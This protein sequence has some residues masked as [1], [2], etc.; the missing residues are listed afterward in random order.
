MNSRSVKFHSDPSLCFAFLLPLFSCV[1]A[2]STSVSRC[3]SCYAY[4]NYQCSFEK[5]GWVC[6]L[7]SGFNEFTARDLKYAKATTRRTVPELREG[8]VE[9]IHHEGDEEEDEDAEHDDPDSDSGPG[10]DAFP[11]TRPTV[12]FLIDA[13][14]PSEYLATVASAV[15]AALDASHPGSL[16]GIASFGHAL[17]VYD[18]RTGASLR[19]PLSDDADPTT[20]PYAQFDLADTWPLEAL[21]QPVRSC[22]ESV[23]RA[24]DAMAL[25]ATRPPAAAPR[26]NFGAA[27]Q[28]LLQFVGAH[29]L[30]C[31]VAPLEGDTAAPTVAAPATGAASFAP[32]P[33]M[34]MNRGPEAGPPTLTRVVSISGLRLFAFLSAPPAEGRG[35]VR[36]SSGSRPVDDLTQKMAGLGGV[37][38]PG[39]PPIPP[40][41]PPPPASAAPADAIAIELPGALAGGLSSAPGSSFELDRRS[42]AFYE[43]A[44][45]AASA[46]GASIDLFVHP[47][48]GFSGV[49]ALAPLATTTGGSVFVYPDATEGTVAQDVLL[50]LATRRAIGCMLRLRTSTEFRVGRAYGHFVPDE[51][52]EDLHHIGACDPHASFAFDFEFATG[53]GFANR[54]GLGSV[55]SPCVQMAFAYSVMTPVLEPPAGPA[56]NGANA[57]TMSPPPPAAS[58][59]GNDG[60]GEELSFP[61]SIP[62]GNPAGPLKPAA[63]PRRILRWVLQRRLRIM[64]VPMPVASRADMLFKNVEPDT[65]CALLVHKV[66]RAAAAEGIDEARALLRDWLVLL[67]SCCVYNRAEGFVTPQNPQPATTEEVLSLLPEAGVGQGSLAI[68]QLPLAVQPLPRLVFA[69]LRSPLLRPA[70]DT[71][72]LDRRAYLQTLW[73]SLAPEELSRAIYPCLSSFVDQDTPGFPRHTLSRA[74]LGASGCS[75]FLLDAYDALMVY[76]GPACPREV[77]FPPPPNSLLRKTVQVLR[78]SRRNTP[79]VH[80]MRAGVDDTMTF[81]ACLVEEPRV[82]ESSFATDEGYLDFAD[83]ILL[84]TRQ[85]IKENYKEGGQ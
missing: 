3:R 30:Q 77:P 10:A 65:C 36:L 56:P 84:E 47:A 72:A 58:G 31:S 28:A 81:D 49:E 69:L 16:V 21:L 18:M 75:L 41:P 40:P 7:C 39:F 23:L 11:E 20:S 42:R 62:L 51:E 25:A 55:G 85:Y 35:A 4:I 48:S 78:T 43:E 76:Y 33:V 12:L 70:R 9:L 6:S 37:G 15:A 73:T 83:A 61:P 66:L 14:S 45:M 44:G 82:D 17:D 8:A 68:D 34:G 32:P 63:P 5:Y 74:A 60:N 71:A 79:A 27:L 59:N 46:L 57:P 80:F 2:S 50:R 38:R 52:L 24:L 29:G 19:V 54:V 1:Q 22:K 53:D 13:A 64:T 26:R 67:I